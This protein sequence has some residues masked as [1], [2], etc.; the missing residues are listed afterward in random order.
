[1]NCGLLV[2]EAVYSGVWTLPRY[3]QNNILLC[4]EATEDGLYVG[5]GSNWAQSISLRYIT[6]HVTIRMPCFA[7]ASVLLIYPVKAVTYTGNERHA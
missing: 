5:R 7:T 3:I 2:Y 1:M 6:L 4:V